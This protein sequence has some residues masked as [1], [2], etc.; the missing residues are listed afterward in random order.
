M[1]L[2]AS[3]LTAVSAFQSPPTVAM[4]SYTIAVIGAN[5]VGKSSLI[6]RVLGLSRR[7]AGHTSTVRMVVDNITHMITLFELDLE[8]FDLNA[9]QPIQWP[10]QINGHVVPRID[11]ALIIYDVTEGNS[12]RFLPQAMSAYPNRRFILDSSSFWSPAN[13][14]CPS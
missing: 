2:T 10:K 4:E 12:I 7:P 13:P 5:G 14:G 3:M 6:Q 9:S 1:L 11:A 8:H